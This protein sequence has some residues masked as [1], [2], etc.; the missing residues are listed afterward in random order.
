MFIWIIATVALLG[1]QAEEADYCVFDAGR[2]SA[3]QTD[4]APRAVRLPTYPFGVDSCHCSRQHSIT[5]G[6]IFA[7]HYLWLRWPEVP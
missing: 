7:T 4:T 5:M 6:W 2:R 1:V 3:Q